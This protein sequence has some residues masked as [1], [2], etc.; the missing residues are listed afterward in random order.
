MHSHVSGGVRNWGRCDTRRTRRFSQRA[1]AGREEIV[2]G[3]YLA[4][5]HPTRLFGGTATPESAT[6]AE[7]T[8]T[9]AESGNSAWICKK[10]AR[11]V[12]EE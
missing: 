7:T 2:V 4:W 10:T 6:P 5:T 8:K 11:R 12:R 9:R 3:A 1:G